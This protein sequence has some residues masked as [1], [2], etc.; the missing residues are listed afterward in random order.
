AQPPPPPACAP[1]TVFG[2]IASATIAFDTDVSGRAQICT[3]D[4]D[5][6]LSPVNPP[7]Y[8]TS[9]G[10]GRQQAQEPEWSL[11]ASA[12]T[13]SDGRIVYQF[14]APG[15]RGIH[16]VKPDGTGDVQLTPSLNTVIQAGPQQGA[17]YPCQDARDPAWS[18]D[19]LYIAYACLT[20]SDYDIWIHS[21][22]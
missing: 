12:G 11:A 22:R 13:D 17:S 4:V 6:K 20:G 10:A 16:L 8:V 1:S 19:G 9:G 15:V 7:A 5:T 3:Q 2:G 21:T 18:P 14:G